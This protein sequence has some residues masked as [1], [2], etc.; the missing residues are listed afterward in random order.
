MVLSIYF[1]ITILLLHF[2]YHLQKPLNFLQNALVFMVVAIIT[3]QCVTLFA[4]EWKLLKMTEDHW[5]FVCM[6]L[7][8]DVLTPML[9]VLFAN[10]YVRAHSPLYRTV[11]FLISLVV[12]VSIHELTVLFHILTYVKWNFFYTILLNAG[13]LLSAVAVLKLVSFIQTMENEQ[14]ES[15]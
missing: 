11:I 6:L 15:L 8:R 12:M 14:N 10:Y 7:C 4:L 3:R 2:A 13:F 1:T 9:T 5:L